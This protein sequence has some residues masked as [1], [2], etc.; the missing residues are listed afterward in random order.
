MAIPRRPCRCRTAAWISATDC[1]KRC[2]SI[3]G[4]P[5]YTG[6]HLERL[7]LGLKVLDIPDC[8]SAVEQYLASAATD[9]SGKGWEWTALRVSVLR[10][11]GPRGYAPGEP[12][13]PRVLLTATRLERNCAEMAGAAALAEVTT[14]LAAQPVLAGIKHLNR[15]EQVLAASESQQRGAD[16]GVML[17]SAGR[18]VSVVAGNLFLVRNGELLTPALS[19]C[20]IRGTRRRLILE[21]WA[22]ALGIEVH[23]TSLTV[24][25]LHNADEVLYSNSLV[26]VRPVASL[27]ASRWSGHPVCEA[28]FDRF[29]EDL[30]C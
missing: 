6:L 5:L 15:L 12:G 7:K 1:S 29:R 3:G 20:G 30:P 13:P 24:D 22:P 11:P 19:D 8:L 17:D 18:L 10:A 25:D 14:R 28:L 21:S 23:E 2:C 9:L 16:E 26:G 27:N 4:N